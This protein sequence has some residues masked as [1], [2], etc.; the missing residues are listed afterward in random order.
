MGL[1]CIWIVN[2]FSYFITNSLFLVFR[3]LFYKFVDW[4]IVHVVKIWFIISFSISLWCNHSFRKDSN[5]FN[6]VE[7]IPKLIWYLCSA[8]F[9][10]VVASL[11]LL[12]LLLLLLYWLRLLSVILEPDIKYIVLVHWLCIK[13]LYTCTSIS[14]WI[15]LY[16]AITKSN[17]RNAD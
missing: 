3:V 5:C 4:H 9:S 11:E 2:L 12:M 7:S 14:L 16:N 8:F 15:V 13:H 6:L 1:L 17:Q 10:R